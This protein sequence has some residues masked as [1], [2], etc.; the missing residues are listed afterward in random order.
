MV[1]DYLKEGCRVTVLKEERKNRILSILLDRVSAR[2]IDIA[3]ELGTSRE[4]V[5]RDLLALHA[6]GRL[7]KIH[8]GA[9]IDLQST[10]KP[11][12]VRMGRNWSEKLE[13]GRRAVDLLPPGSAV[14]LDAGSTTA[15]F[16]EV[17]RDRATDIKVIT[18]LQPAAQML[19]PKAFLLG[20]TYNEDV[21]A[22]FGELTLANISRFYADF[23]IVSPT[24][25]HRKQGLM[26][27]ELHECEVARAM[28]E[29]AR[30][31]IVLADA[32]KLDAT[33]RV[34]LSGTDCVDI[35]LTNSG[36]SPNLLNS[37]RE[38]IP[39]VL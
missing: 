20:G 21:P 12:Q 34:R 10:E 25:I 29:N 16:A 22:T 31:T 18:N 32:N 39:E 14:F 1:T 38:Q 11:F 2:T 4:T 26:Y 24:A 13:I 8:G 17:L 30:K 37:F 19:G 6:E 9:T 27:Y 3:A 36:T 5:R 33:S 23:A 28:I 7:E 15:A 35:L